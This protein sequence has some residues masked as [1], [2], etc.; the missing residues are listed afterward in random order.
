VVQVPSP[1][2]PFLGVH[3]TPRMDGSLLL[4][5]NAVPAFSREGYTYSDINL[6]VLFLYKPLLCDCVA[7]S[8][9]ESDRVYGRVLPCMH[10]MRDV[11]CPD[12][13]F[14]ADGTLRKWSRSRDSSGWPG[15]IWLMA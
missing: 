7:L 5:P 3:F 13:P 2:L 4:G 9:A 14:C 10:V 12:V 8:V 6:F 1:G 11:V 15:R